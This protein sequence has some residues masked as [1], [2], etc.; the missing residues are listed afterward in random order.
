MSCFYCVCC[1]FPNPLGYVINEEVLFSHMGKIVQSERAHI[2]N[3]IKNNY[4]KSFWCTKVV[5]D[6][7]KAR[8]QNNKNMWAQ[9]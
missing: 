1:R 9:Q 7:G 6:E 4:K 2:M 8:Y 3:A 5:W